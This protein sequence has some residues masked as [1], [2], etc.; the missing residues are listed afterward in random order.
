MMESSGRLLVG[1]P[2]QG[3]MADLIKEWILTKEYFKA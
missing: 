1:L 3:L 2:K